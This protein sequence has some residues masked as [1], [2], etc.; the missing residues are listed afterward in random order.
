MNGRQHDRR[1]ERAADQ[2][3]A[4]GVIHEFLELKAITGHGAA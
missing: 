3:V 2:S 1:A 4:E